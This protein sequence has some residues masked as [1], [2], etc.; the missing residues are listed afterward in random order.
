MSV[1]L[2]IP[3]ING[4]VTE[5]NHVKWIQVESMS[6]GVHRSVNT[7]VGRATD[8]E[9]SQ[10]SVTEFSFTK[11]MDESSIEMFGWAVASFTTKDCKV[12]ITAT[13]RDDPFI[14][15]KLEKAV[16][17]SY[18]V[19]APNE[20]TPTEM[21]TLN[22]TKVEEKFTPIGPDMKAGAPVTKAYDLATGKAS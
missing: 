15:Y 20:G 17:A 19:G 14:S 10:P 1:Y 13:G 8:R 16:I 18:T 2:F 22:F 11:T 4:G 7:Q 12:E 9:H 5:K 6:F 21:F 3:S